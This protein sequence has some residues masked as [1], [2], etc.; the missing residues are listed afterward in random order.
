VAAEF[1]ALADILRP[2]PGV[3]ALDARPQLGDES[4]RD[5]AALGSAA[6]TANDAAADICAAVRE[7]RLFRA[8]LADALDAA[9]ARLIREL[10][11]E[12]L[13]RELKLAP[14]DIDVLVRRIHERAPVVRVRVA[15]ADVPHLRAAPCVA[16]PAL[17]AGDA[18][19][20]LHGGALDARLGVRLATVLDGFA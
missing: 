2:P 12:V 15:P 1:T 11:S 18:L 9:A 16:D 7:A 8:R 13:A 10:A 4:E 3:A 17:A 5:G 19:V 6:E 20:E 14:C